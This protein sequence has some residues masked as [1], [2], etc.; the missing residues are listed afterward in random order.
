MPASFF[1]SEGS[2]RP[3][4]VRAPARQVSLLVASNP[5]KGTFGILIK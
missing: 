5:S 4:S 3:L 1:C 2:G